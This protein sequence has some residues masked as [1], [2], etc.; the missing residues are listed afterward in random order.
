METAGIIYN[1][2]YNT[3]KTMVH[4][5]KKTSN[6]IRPKQYKIIQKHSIY[7]PLNTR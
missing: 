1:N 2:T 7:N 3:I 4:V 5:L 6:R